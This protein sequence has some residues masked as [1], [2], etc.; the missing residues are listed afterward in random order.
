MWAG[1]QYFS[2]H[3]TWRHG[4]SGQLELRILPNTTPNNQILYCTSYN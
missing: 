3:D 1:I 2:T 4:F